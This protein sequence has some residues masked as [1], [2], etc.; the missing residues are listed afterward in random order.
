MSLI[1]PRNQELPPV[2]NHDKQYI[3]GAWVPSSS[4]ASIDVDNAATEET[5]A[6]VP[7]G[8]AEDADR[9]VRAAGAA[10]GGWSSL[11]LEKRCEFLQAAADG[12]AART[13]EIARAITAEVGM[14][15]KLSQRIQAALPPQVMAGYARL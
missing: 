3:D 1:I 5:I 12:L 6:R 9:A 13:E 15:L 8:A 4:S 11:P 14:P 10:F 2:K 7:E